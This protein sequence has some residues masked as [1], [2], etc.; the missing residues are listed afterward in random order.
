MGHAPH[1]LF[2]LLTLALPAAAQA[3]D[4]TP[5]AP[6]SPTKPASQP[7][8][9]VFIGDFG[10]TT[11]E[12]FAVAALVRALDPRLVITLG[13]N[14]YPDGKASTIDANIGQHYH[15]FIA[16]YTGGYG[17]GAL[18]N[19]FF[20]CLGNHDWST[21]GAVPYLDYF[22]LPGNERY[23]DFRR[24][25]VHFFALDSDPS[26]PDGNLPGSVQGQWLESKLR[27]S[28]A[29]FKIVYQHHG[30]YN[31][32]D[33]HGP[34]ADSQWPFKE[35]GAS[36]V[37]NG[38]DHLYERVSIS[39]L[40]YITNGLGGRNEYDFMTPIGGSQVRFNAQHGA[41]LMRADDEFA[42]FQFLTSGDSVQDDFVL[43]RGGVD[44]GTT[45]LIAEDDL[46]SYR[47]TG[48]YPG[49]KWNQWGY[50]DSSWAVGRAQ[51]GYGES[52]QATTV[53]YGGDAN[54]RYVTT[55]FRHEFLLANPHEFETLQLRLLHDDGAVVYLNG[56]EVARVDMPA[57]PITPT[58]LATHSAT[59]NEERTFYPFTFG[60]EHLLE[61]LPRQLSPGRNV[62][63]VELHQAA[64]NSSDLSFSAE[65]VGL[66]RGRTLLPRGSSWR[67]LDGGAVPDA[68]WAQPGFDDSGWLAGPAQL[69][70]GEGD[71]AT[72]T[73]AL[74][75][76]TWFRGTFSLADLA[77][78]RWLE[79]RLLRDD[80]ALVYLNGV[81]AARFDLPRTGVGA[82]TP[83][84][85]DV[86]AA[87][88]GRFEDTP[89]DPRLLVLG[90]NTIAVELHQF[91]ASTDLSFDL[92]LVA[93]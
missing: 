40:Q 37:L 51:L 23:Y 45:I 57:G 77:S 63:A 89:I 74:G 13:D 9:C 20:P 87:D 68:A 21:A 59:G 41:M 81:E 44:P 80:G 78:V 86:P 2:L 4:P 18:R 46:W 85:F 50:D 42:H 84:S 72:P 53:G 10:T 90:A 8:E 43:P 3:S 76:T 64:V 5:H 65:L 52:D 58:T 31:S 35:W 19:R 92:E 33:S 6:G 14:N 62:L 82:S 36:L 12:S 54:H 17:A 26:E 75:T 24:G 61:L 56:F 67:Y 27:A 47:D 11:P 79:L 38:H 22:E 29:P 70:F 66:Q 48:V 93:H 30:P 71:E 25:P 39:G 15:Q 73:S 7:L 28:N 91:A 1:T 88:E 69:G 55:W 49:T 34:Q 16:P 60:A 32:S 83:A